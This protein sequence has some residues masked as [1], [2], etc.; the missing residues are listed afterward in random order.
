[1]SSEDLFSRPARA[2]KRDYHLLNDGSDSEAET[3]D[4][5]DEL[6]YP[7]MRS[8]SMQSQP[9][10]SFDSQSIEYAVYYIYL[11]IILINLVL[12]L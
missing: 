1:M 11:R 2:L 4:R 9:I 5:I 10:Y 8:H 7:L 12:L 3:E 6:P